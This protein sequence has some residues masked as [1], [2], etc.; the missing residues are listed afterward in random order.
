MY[1]CVYTLYVCIYYKHKYG[2]TLKFIYMNI[3]IKHTCVYINIYIH[4]HIYNLLMFI[5]L[6]F[7]HKICNE[8]CC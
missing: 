2:L 3:H 1:V 7:L 8:L 6:K 5:T 4:T